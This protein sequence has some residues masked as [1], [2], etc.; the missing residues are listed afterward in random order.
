[1]FSAVA[2][3]VLFPPTTS[4]CTMVTVAVCRCWDGACRHVDYCACRH[5]DYSFFIDTTFTLQRVI[6]HALTH[7]I[8]IRDHVQAATTYQ[9]YSINSTTWYKD[10]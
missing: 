1:M 9:E 10:A 5:V 4:V 8:T 3:V 7:F 2:A 6:V